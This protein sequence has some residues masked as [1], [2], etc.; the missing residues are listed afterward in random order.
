MSHRASWDEAWKRYAARVFHKR[1][2]E[3][4]VMDSMEWFLLEVSASTSQNEDEQ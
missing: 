4:R 1:R 3:A 2:K